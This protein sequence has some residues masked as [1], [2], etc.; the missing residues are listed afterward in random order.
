MRELTQTE[1]SHV[2]GGNVGALVV[3]G[4]TGALVF[5][6]IAAGVMLYINYLTKKK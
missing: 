5:G 2:N 4:L 6:V 3:G 1:V